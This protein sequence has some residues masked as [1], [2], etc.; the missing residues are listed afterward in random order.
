MS[1][2][3]PHRPDGIGPDPLEPPQPAPDALGPD[4]PAD[5]DT[6]HRDVTAGTA[7]DPTA[8]LPADTDDGVSGPVAA[9]AVFEAGLVGLLGLAEAAWTGLAADELLGV[10]KGFESI[11]NRMVQID[12]QL[13]HA[14][15]I[16]RLA[17]RQAFATTTQL[18]A[19]TVLIR[20]AEAAGRVTTT[21]EL[22]PS[23]SM[24]GEPVEPRRPYLAAAVATGRVTP[25]H[26]Q[27]AL[28]AL[29]KI[30][31]VAHTTAEQVERAEQD[32]ASHAPVLTPRQF[33]VFADKLVDVIDPDG[34]LPD[35]RDHEG[36]RGLNWWETR[37]GSWRIEGRITPALAQ[38]LNAVFDPLT[39]PQ[40]GPDGPDVRDQPQR[41]HD[42]LEMLLDR[43]LRGPGLPEFGGTPTTVFVTINYQ[44]LLDETGHGTF[45]DG[46]PIA[47]D[48]LLK[49]AAQADILP[50][51]LTSEGQVLHLGRSQRIASKHLT[52]ALY[53]RDK[54]CSFPGCHVTPQWCERHHIH[55]WHRDGETNLDNMTLL[56]RY[57]HHNFERLAWTC[58]LN[59]D[60]IPEWTPPAYIDPTQTPITNTRIRHAA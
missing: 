12:H 51:V 23:V 33:Q 58:H 38:K 25:T 50:V 56:C 11:R 30:G 20:T 48:T 29:G 28:R 44:D 4:G 22:R 31:K 27:I 7:A 60:G 1:N 55:P 46:T 37:D 34:V 14:S 3:A 35:D 19:G 54:G 43:I 45:T 41:T 42:A 32:L 52:H 49:M 5:R 13:V 9:L 53:A 40:D 18:L 16:T 17:D 10:I 59:N 8:G 15:T 57:H 2:D 36:R 39:L 47:T 21:R 26:T 6:P 24:T